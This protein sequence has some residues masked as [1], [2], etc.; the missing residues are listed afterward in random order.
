MLLG[1][2]YAIVRGNFDSE[3]GILL[4]MAPT[5]LPWFVCTGMVALGALLGAVAA[6][7]SLRRLL[8]V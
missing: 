2:L 7:G 8:L 1:V 3:L 6:Y 4:G 5:F